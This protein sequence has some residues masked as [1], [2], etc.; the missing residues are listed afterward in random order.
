M[1]AEADNI[2]PGQTF[3]TNLGVDNRGLWGG[4]LVLGNAPSSL[5]GDVASYQ[6]EGIPADDTRG[7]YGG[8]NT[9]D[10]SGT[11]KYISIRHG[12]ALIGQDNE[13]NGSYRGCWK[14]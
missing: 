7:L 6:I 2:Q 8:T 9:S 11:M 3:G 14:C 13:I 1:T 10:N 12:G 4:L 5:K